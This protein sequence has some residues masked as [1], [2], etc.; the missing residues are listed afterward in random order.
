MFD[1]IAA[2]YYQ[3]KVFDA[4]EDSS[5]S[6]SSSDSPAY[7]VYPPPGFA[8]KATSIGSS[9]SSLDSEKNTAR[10][11]RNIS[12][13]N[14]PDP[15]IQKNEHAILAYQELL[16]KGQGLQNRISNHIEVDAMFDLAINQ[17]LIE[18]YPDELP[19]GPVTPV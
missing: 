5:S 8:D 14:S 19:D 4:L 3:E 7:V 17:I 15:W 1:E 10:R 9:L 16:K 11:A 18:E 2:R 13:F 6:P 12:V